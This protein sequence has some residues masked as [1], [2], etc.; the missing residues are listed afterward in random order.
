MGQKTVVNTQLSNG[1][2][3]EFYSTE[4]QGSRSFVLNSAN[5][6]LNKVGVVATY[7]AGE[8]DQAGIAASTR[9]AGIIGF[10][11]T[12]VRPTL[13]NVTSIDNGVAAELIN[14]GYVLV[15]LAAVAAKGDFVYYSNT[16]GVISTVAPTAVSPAGATRLPGG[17]VEIFNV[18]AAGIAVIYL[19][20]AG[21]K[22]DST[23]V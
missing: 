18:T 3:G 19:D 21:D 23:G 12:L 5:A 11:K 8:D 4:P 1:L 20:H 9:F 13:E 16:T 10:P 7:V 15:T 6:A 14:R 22:S 17:T 2:P